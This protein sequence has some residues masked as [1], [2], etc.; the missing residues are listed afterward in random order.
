MQNYFHT[1]FGNVPHL[2]IRKSPYSFIPFLYLS[3]I[4]LYG[5]IIAF[6]R[7]HRIY[8]TW[9][10]PGCRYYLPVSST[11]KMRGN[12]SIDVIQ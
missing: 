8:G 1:F 6:F 4:A 10:H 3:E 11:R 12:N 2:L 7:C 5:E 9:Y